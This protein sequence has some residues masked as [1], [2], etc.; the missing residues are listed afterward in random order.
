MKKEINEIVEKYAE[1]IYR[2]AYLILKSKSDAEDIVQDVL[3]K[4]MINTKE[5]A[6][7]EHERN[8]LVRVTLNLCKNLTTS[9]WRRHTVPIDEECLNLEV[10]DKIEL[11]DGLNKLKEN[12]RIVVQLFYYEDLSVEKIS[13]ILN[14][15]ETNVRARLSRAR[16]ELKKV[17]EKQKES[18]KNM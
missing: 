16:K 4:Y 10:E 1:T 13:K 14:I 12:S 17:L 2:I 3:V 8:W 7:E 15:S 9:A 11:F 5:F 18:Y 6:C